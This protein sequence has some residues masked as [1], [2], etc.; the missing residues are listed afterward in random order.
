L[1][2]RRGKLGEFSVPG[3]QFPEKAESWKPIAESLFSK[4]VR[5]MPHN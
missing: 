3:S 4:I 2:P 5:T 1:L